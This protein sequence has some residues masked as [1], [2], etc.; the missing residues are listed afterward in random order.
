MPATLPARV[1]AMN[2]SAL[3]LHRL[4]RDAPRVSFKPVSHTLT[5]RMDA[6]MLLTVAPGAPLFHVWYAIS[7]YVPVMTSCIAPLA[8]MTSVIGLI[9]HWRVNPDD[10]EHSVSDARGVFTLNCFS[11]AL[12]I[13][14]NFLFLLNFSARATYLVTQIISIISWVSASAFLLI[15]IL[16]T[17]PSFIGGP[18]VPSEGYWYAVV[19]CG[20]YALCAILLIINFSG[21]ILGKFPPRFNLNPQ[22]RMLMLFTAFWSIWCIIGLVVMKNVVEDLTYGAALYFCTVS[23]LTIGLGDITPKTSLAKALL[24]ILSIGGVF[25]MGLIIAM[26]RGAVMSLHGP[27]LFWHLVERQRAHTYR[28]LD[29]ENKVLA[30]DEAFDKIRDIRR[31]T[32]LRQDRVA[33]VVQFCFFLVFWMGG[34]AVFAAVEKWTYFNGLYFCLL[35]LL[36]IG[37]GDYTPEL[38]FGRAFFV[39]WAVAAVPLMTILVSNFGDT[40]FAQASE[41]SS[42]LNKT[43]IGRALQKLLASHQQNRGP[44]GVADDVVEPERKALDPADTRGGSPANSPIVNPEKQSTTCSR[45]V[46]PEKES[47]ASSPVVDSEKTKVTS[48]YTMDSQDKSP[49]SSPIALSSDRNSVSSLNASQDTHKVLVAADSASGDSHRLSEIDWPEL[50]TRLSARVREN[51]R[52]VAEIHLLFQNL[53]MLFTDAA[54]N[55]KKSYT[56]E[57]W[58]SILQVHS[59]SDDRRTGDSARAFSPHSPNFWLSQESPLRLPLKEPHYLIQQVLTRIELS[60]EGLLQSEAQQ[61]RRLEQEASAKTNV[62]KTGPNG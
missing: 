37:Y 3:S 36:T 34:A 60:I 25:N 42:W 17:R 10:S 29:K 62:E 2:R 45:A 54:E 43:A 16:L 14:G 47:P 48:P 28:K 40:L 31:H 11:L 56:R 35:C 33:L 49:T 18:Y 53:G 7:A 20:V 6:L 19:T 23:F 51:E 22:Q 26:I 8:N 9:Q 24:L 41:V 44:D 21:Y 39:A 55:P 52:V 5:V 46:D 27:T 1:S 61:L 58:C 57:Q 50:C 12:G 15:A 59:E 4:S 13:I 32:L 38:S 30:P